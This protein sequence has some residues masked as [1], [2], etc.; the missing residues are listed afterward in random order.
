MGHDER[1]LVGEPP[2]VEKAISY[3]E[4]TSSHQSH[5]FI[6]SVNGKRELQVVNGYVPRNRGDIPAQASLVSENVMPLEADP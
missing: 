2:R 5:L 4:M 3:R 1:V 6:A